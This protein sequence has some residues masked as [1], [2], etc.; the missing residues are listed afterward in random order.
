MLT[1][2]EKPP[3]RVKDLNCC[4]YCGDHLPATVKEHIFNS[5]WGGSHKSSHLICNDCNSSF[6]QQTDLAFTFYAKAVMNAWSIKGERHQE[7]PKIILNNEYYLDSGA[8]LKLKK[9]LIEEKVLANGNISSKL[10]FNSR[11]QAKRWLERDGLATLLERNPSTKEREYFEKLIK[12]AELENADAEPQPISIQLNLREQYRSTAHTVL[13]CLGFFLPEWVQKDL[14][15][16]IR[17]FARYNEGDWRSFAVVAEQM[18]PINE[19]AKTARHLGINYNSVEVYFCSSTKMII[20]VLTILDQI[21]RAI[22]IARDYTGPDLI[23]YAVEGTHGFSKP[24]ESVLV[25]FQPEHI[26][27]PLIGAQFFLSSNQVYQYFKNEL[28]E[29]MEMQF[30]TD[31]LTARLIQDIE[32]KNKKNLELNQVNLEEYLEIFL[33]FFQ[34]FG[35]VFSISLDVDKIRFQLLEHGF[36]KLANQH[37]GTLYTDPEVVSLMGLAFQHTFQDLLFGKLSAG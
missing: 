36:T 16:S 7:V 2:L 27:V 17:Q 12:E 1:R 21:K 6:S 37:P 25:R 5:S 8:K 15:S 28:S 35:K 20:G 19:L 24:P 4:F 13:K 32:T 22:V 18:I 9:P 3:I 23:L 10:I 29:L 33:S 26:S 34:G 31:A 11:N 14:T 30:P